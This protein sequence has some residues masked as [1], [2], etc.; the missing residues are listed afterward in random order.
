[1][2]F[3]KH[4]AIGLVLAAVLACLYGGSV[5]LTTQVPDDA[6]TGILGGPLVMAF[7]SLLA[8]LVFG[9]IAYVYISRRVVFRPHFR[10]AVPV[11]ILGTI[12][13][14]QMFGSQ[15]FYAAM[16]GGLLW[17]LYLGAFAGALGA[18]GRDHGVVLLV[19]AISIGCGLLALLGIVE[20]LGMMGS[21]PGYRIF[22]GW[23]NPNA[24]AGVFV[25]GIPATIGLAALSNGRP[26]ALLM[27]VLVLSGA[28]LMLTQS[29]GGMVA[30]TIGIVVACLLISIWA[31]PKRSLLP[32]IATVSGVLVAIGLRTLGAGSAEGAVGRV[33]EGA[34]QEHSAGFRRSLWQTAADLIQMSPSGHGAGSFQYVSALPGHNTTTVFAHQSF[35]ELG[36]EMGLAGLAAL[37]GLLVLWIVEVLR[38]P[39]SLTKQQNLLRAGIVGAV[40]ATCA[41]SMIDS[42]LSYTGIGLLFFLLL[43]AGL[44]VSA[45]GVTPEPWPIWFRQTTVVGLAVVP[46]IGFLVLAYQESLKVSMVRA[47]ES[48][49]TQ[50]IRKI[51]PELENFTLRD[52]EAFFLLSI[53]YATSEQEQLR[54]LLAAAESGPRPSYFRAIA[55]MEER[56]GNTAE[57]QK[58]LKDALAWD[59]NNLQSLLQLMN[60]AAANN[61]IDKAREHAERLV[62]VES[63][64][65]YQ[66]RSI[67]EAVPTETAEA[68]LF[69]ASLARTAAE[70]KDLLTGAVAIYANYLETTVPIIRRFAQADPP[71]RFSGQGVQEAV[72][73]LESA[74][75]AAHLLASAAEDVNDLAA[76]EAAVA[77]GNEFSSAVSELTSSS[78][79]AGAGT[80]SGSR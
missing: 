42:N 61:E 25:I 60:L 76:A 23:I 20:Y 44:L 37:L 65:Y 4:P 72:D 29:R 21:E 6:I 18:L 38:A 17:L 26:H 73:V 47:G 63:S 36:S 3:L 28:A 74:T 22:A 69:L 10:F 59:P 32:L 7:R 46:I 13:V 56:R 66:V 50:Q 71:L 34:A 57:A 11:L 79:S 27:I 51:G 70:R 40:L 53:Y 58:A 12:C 41:Q 80:T 48:G 33:A 52:D 39:K 68:R 49:D 2:S 14:L 55:R 62:A 77:A 64:R 75:R 30:A 24:L 45:D 15:F 43:G 67:P 31:A 1:M 5:S 78:T 9:T 19:G 8:L 16:A 35:L 54:F